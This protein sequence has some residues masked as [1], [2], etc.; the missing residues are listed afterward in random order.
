MRR[1]ALAVFIALIAA[2]AFA[3]D[4][5]Q[6]YREPDK[7]KSYIEQ[8]ADKKAER[9][10]QRALKSVPDK[11]QNDPWGIAR[12]GDAAQGAAK[13]PANPAPTKSAAKKPASK[14]DKPPAAAAN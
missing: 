4:H 11:Q 2:P 7:E 6:G 8:Q 14:Q 13:T 3:Q 9:D 1:I 12:S 10:Y 5:V